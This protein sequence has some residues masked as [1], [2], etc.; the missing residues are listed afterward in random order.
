[1]VVNKLLNAKS[2]KSTVKSL[3]ITAI[4]IAY[5]ATIQLQE[6]VLILSYP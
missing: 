4:A 6:L 5:N 2:I 3:F 1:M